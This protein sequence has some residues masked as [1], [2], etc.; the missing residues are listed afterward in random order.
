MRLISILVLLVFHPAAIAS[1]EVFFSPRDD[2]AERLIGEIRGAK[3]SLDIA[4][5]QFTSVDVAEALI[6]AKDRGVRIRIVADEKESLSDSSLV[7]SLEEEGL[8][9]KSI[10]YIKGRFG[11]KMHHGFIIFD[12]RAV[13]TGSYNLTDYSDKFNFENAILTDD[14]QLVAKYQAQ[15][16]KLYGE[17]LVTKRPATTKDAGEGRQFIGLSISH[18][19][20]LLGKDSM[21]SDSD[22][23]TLWSHCKNQFVRGEGQIISSSVDPLTGPTV[24]IRD[25]RGTEIEIFL[26]KDETDKVPKMSGG[27]PVSFTGRLTA[28]PGVTRDYF[29]LDHG[30]IN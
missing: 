30:H 7:P 10:R 17:P 6:G 14:P 8:D 11:G 24:I 13:M 12:S 22:K 29:K 2:V 1:T 3:D 19:G 9:G 5:F 25:E 27:K 21:L 20:R 23:K 4:S 26:D 16:N 15:F 18:L 28:R